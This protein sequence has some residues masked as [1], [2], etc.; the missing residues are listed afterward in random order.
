LP[1]LNL[2]LY[3]IAAPDPSR[4]PRSSAFM[5]LNKSRYCQIFEPA[6]VFPPLI[7]KS[8][9]K[10]GPPVHSRRYQRPKPKADDRVPHPSRFLRR[11]GYHRSSGF[12]QEPPDHPA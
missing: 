11:V 5:P 8:G 12:P 1:L 3:G 4:V 10:N 2:Y 9:F 7:P 6:F